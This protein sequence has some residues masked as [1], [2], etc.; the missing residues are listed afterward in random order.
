MKIDVDFSIAAEAQ[1]RQI[2]TTSETKNLVRLCIA[3]DDLEERLV[4]AF[5]LAQAEHRRLTVVFRGEQQAKAH[6]EPW[7]EAP[8]G[9]K[10]PVGLG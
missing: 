3:D 4:G 8:C 10:S 5:N 7:K 1:D 9:E 2:R 6:P